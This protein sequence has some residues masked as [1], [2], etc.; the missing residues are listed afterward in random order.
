MREEPMSTNPFQEPPSPDP[1]AGP[2]EGPP[3]FFPDAP[4]PLPSR[5]WKVALQ[6]DFWSPAEQAHLAVCPHC[7]SVQERVSA[8]AL[9]SR[10]PVIG[11]SLDLPVAPELPTRQPAPGPGMTAAGWFWGSWLGRG[12]RA[13]GSLCGRLA[14]RPGVSQRQP[15]RRRLGMDRL[16]DRDV[17]NGFLPWNGGWQAAT[18]MSADPGDRDRPVVVAGSGPGSEVAVPGTPGQDEQAWLCA[19]ASLVWSDPAPEPVGA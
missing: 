15:P 19:F 8:A 3:G 18:M 1:A 16:E 12:L 6:L 14:P 13:L 9:T 7:R 17:L 11:S 10:G 2:A 4:C 5:F